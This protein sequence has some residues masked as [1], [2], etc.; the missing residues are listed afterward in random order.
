MVVM[1]EPAHGVP[2]PGSVT[3][4]VSA[5]PTVPPG[6]Y[7]YQVLSMPRGTTRSQARQVLTEHAEYGHWELA[8]VRLYSGGRRRVWL[9]R[10]IIRIAR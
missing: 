9:R 4:V 6:D 3:P 7:E 8:R 2:T 10:K 5:L 1:S